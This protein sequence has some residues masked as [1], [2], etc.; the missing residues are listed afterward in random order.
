MKHFLLSCLTLVLMAFASNSTLAQCVYTSTGLGDGTFFTPGT[1]TINPITFA[2]TGTCTGNTTPA[3]SVFVINHNVIL[4]G[5]FI[6]NGGSIT[7]GTAGSLRQDAT[8][9]KLTITNNGNG[10]E[11]Q[12]TIVTVPV[13]TTNAPQLSVGILDLLRTTANIGVN[14]TVRVN[15]TL[16]VG[17]SVT[18]NLG[19]NSLLNV[20]GDVDVATASS[21]INGPA[22]GSPAGLR[23]AGNV[24]N[25]GGAQLFVATD[26]LTTCVQQITP[27]PCSVTTQNIVTPPAS[28]DPSCIS[29][30][31]VTLTRFVGQWAAGGAAVNLKWATATEIDNDYFAVERSADGVNFEKIAQVKGAGNSSMVR[32]YAHTDASPLMSSSY[33]R[34]RQ[35]DYDG[36]ATYSP[37][38][39][40][41][42]PQSS[43]DWLIGTSSP[44][45]FTIQSQLDA[46]S[47]FAVLD[48][49]GRPVFSQAVSRE[50]ADVVIPSLPT[51]VY[52]FRLTTKQGRFT[53]RQV[54]TAGN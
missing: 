48:V 42:V 11:E 9:R 23:I 45:H 31:P 10:S 47:R 46:N 43:I 40:L 4:N 30:L 21:V 35:V 28:N 5:D 33:Y 13:Q 14:S 36:K 44:R 17:T 49:T 24:R 37:I 2:Q 54:V 12:L 6:I 34:L 53:V 41:G 52:L 32:N 18:V 16:F 7:I 25:N 22:T 39:S 38:I 8:N 50:N 19:N 1:T 29:V 26:L 27:I 3:S 20:L 15:C 51:G